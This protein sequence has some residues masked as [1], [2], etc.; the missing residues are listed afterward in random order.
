ML[1][2]GTVSI[3]EHQRPVAPPLSIIPT[4]PF[5]CA[6]PRRQAVGDGAVHLEDLVLA[7]VHE[8]ALDGILVISGDGHVLSYNQRFATMWGVSI[9]LLARKND[10]ILLQAVTGKL[11]APQ[12]FLDGVN[13]LYEHQDETSRDEIELTDG[14]IFDRYSAP[15]HLGDQYFGRVWYF[16]DDT[17]RR[18]A[19]A[20]S[21]DSE[22]ELRVALAAA[23]MGT[24]DW[25]LMTDRII[26]SRGSET[27]FG[28]SPGGFGGTNDPFERCVHP[29]DLSSLIGTVARCIA[30]RTPFAAE[31]RVTWP[32]GSEHWIAGQGEFTFDDGGR[33]VRLHGI[34]L[35]VTARKQSEEQLRQS[36][37]NTVAALAATCET[38]D[39]YTAGHQRRV[40][41]L[42]VA[43]AREL[44][45][46]EA[47]VHCV[48]LASI[49]HDIGKIKIPVEILTSPR[50]LS[51]VEIQLVQT[52][53]EA[54]YEI[55]K[56]IDFP[57]PIAE[58]VRQ[59]HERL[60][61]SGY[62]RGLQ[63]SQILLE[64]RIIAVA[65]TIEAMSSNRPYR[66]GRGIELALAELKSNRG[67]LYDS[68]VVDA[69]VTLFRTN[70]FAF[71]E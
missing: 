30:K 28:F 27:L 26:W 13:Y 51:P 7:T 36:M 60:D 64:A 8:L 49:L 68:D 52:H 61:G 16:R 20:A 48:H 29:Q 5:L 4:D 42:A 47:Q 44:R 54:G 57:W 9:D 66:F 21:R 50:A 71:L 53:V 34:A 3:P 59:H 55:L 45:L 69:C 70:R 41:E 18:R 11:V 37:E 25:H 22:N 62:P 58:F 39:P 23:R 38:R 17:E 10:A 15:I 2:E 31:F 12:K 24:F 67:L 6:H 1:H 14:R 40:A 19:E 56:G 65:D 33:A 63:G 35:D 43:I 46:D 32:D